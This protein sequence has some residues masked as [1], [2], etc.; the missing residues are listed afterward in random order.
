MSYGPTFRSEFAEMQQEVHR[1]ALAHGWYEDDDGNPV[2][3]NDGELI[4]LMHSE[5]S[6]ALEALRNGNPESEKRIF[7]R[8]GQVDLDGEWCPDLLTCVEEEL[9]DVVIRIM[10]YAE[11]RGFDVAQAIVEKHNYNK[12]R[13]HRHGGKA[14]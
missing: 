13:P 3:R 1:N 4:A 8:K 9:A 5:L 6:E 10:D 14:F 12:G 7:A 11:Y 2:E